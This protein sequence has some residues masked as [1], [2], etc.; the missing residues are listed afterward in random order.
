MSVEKKTT[1]NKRDTKIKNKTKQYNFRSIPRRFAQISP[2]HLN[3]C[4]LG[5][6]QNGD[7]AFQYISCPKVLLIFKRNL[8]K[9]LI[10]Y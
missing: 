9:N 6:G 1:T 3:H 5:Y 10:E 4:L 8:A 7:E 2:E